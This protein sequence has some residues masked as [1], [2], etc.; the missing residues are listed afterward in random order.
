MYDPDIQIVGLKTIEKINPGEELTTNIQLVANNK[1]QTGKIKFTF[2]IIEKTGFDLEPEKVIIVPTR[3]FQPPKLVIVDYAIDDQNRNLKVEKREIVDVTIR[4]QNQGETPSYGTK[5][6]LKLGENVLAVDARDLYD[7]GDINAGEFKDIKASIVTNTRA[8]EVVLNVGVSEATNKSTAYKTINLPFDVVQK[9][10]DEIVIEQK[11]L[12]SFV[13]A[14]SFLSKL[15]LAENIPVAK[16][17][18]NNAVAVIIGNKNYSRAPDVDFA[19]NDAA[20]VKNYVI[21]A[22]GYDKDNIIYVEDASQ[23]DFGIIFGNDQNYKGKLF[24]YTRKDVSE[25]FIYYSGHGAPDTDTKKGFLVPVDC[26]PN[27]VSLNGYGLSTLYSNLDKISKEKSLKHITV[28]VDACF[29]GT[30]SAGSLLSNISPIYITTENQTLTTP[31]SAVFTSASGDQV[32]NWYTE[33]KQSLFTYFFLKGLKGEADLDKNGEI[34]TKELY[35]YTADEVNGVPYWARRINQRT[36]TP[37][38]FGEDF[39][40]IK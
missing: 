27:R 29:S 7:F 37:T 32:S 33:K 3:E 20:L 24:D 38:F 4:I 31:N 22:L 13:S 36:Q 17:R 18:N 9:K 23:S 12:P 40:L 35:Q 5:A 6:T 34:T 14:T 1:I 11:N 15:D 25:V 8:T 2:K 39:V 30:S 16:V 19:L 28:V 26:D 10:V 21:T